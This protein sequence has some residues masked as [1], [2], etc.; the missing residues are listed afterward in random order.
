[1]VIHSSCECFWLCCVGCHLSM[2]WWAV[3]CPHPGSEPATPWAAEAKRVNLTTQPRGRPLGCCLKQHILRFF[4]DCGESESFDGGLW[5]FHNHFGKTC[6]GDLYVHK[7][8]EP[9]TWGTGVCRTIYKSHQIYKYFCCNSMYSFLKNEKTH[10]AKSH[11]K[12]NGA[13]GKRKTRWRELKTCRTV[14][15]APTRIIRI[16]I[17]NCSTVTIPIFVPNSLV[18]S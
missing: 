5:I 9:L 4:S 3:P 8:W 12:N 17:R 14:A 10:F 15:G 11:S 1:M 6:P 16:L 18:E 13:S 2:A 7:I